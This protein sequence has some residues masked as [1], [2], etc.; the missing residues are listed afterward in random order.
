VSWPQD[1]ECRAFVSE[2]ELSRSAAGEQAEI[3][4]KASVRGHSGTL[5]QATRLCTRM[6]LL[7][8]RYCSVEECFRFADPP[9]VESRAGSVCEGAGS[10]EHGPGLLVPPAAREEA[11]VTD[12]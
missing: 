3:T 1:W 11:C 8:G 5:A 4:S 10:G 12:E 2:I 7:L 9:F 6:M